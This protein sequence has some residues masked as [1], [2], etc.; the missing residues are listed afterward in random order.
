[1]VYVEDL[2]ELNLGV[3][4]EQLP[5]WGVATQVSAVAKPKTTL[6]D[7]GGVPKVAATKYELSSSFRDSHPTRN[8]EHQQ[9][10]PCAM[11]TRA[12][13]QVDRPDS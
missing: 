12:K 10:R 11:R 5:H 8:E 7:C 9:G 3:V 1:M 13:Q 4:D 2:D 6:S